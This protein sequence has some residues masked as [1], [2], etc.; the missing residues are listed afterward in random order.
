M[1][2]RY[3]NDEAAMAY[4]RW[5]ACAANSKTNEERKKECEELLKK[6]WIETKK[7]NRMYLEQTEMNEIKLN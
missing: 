5:K 1:L 7:L 6:Y 4:V 2:K 3:K